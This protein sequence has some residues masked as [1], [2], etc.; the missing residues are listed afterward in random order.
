MTADWQ[1]TPP[2]VKGDDDD[3]NDDSGFDSDE[4][5]ALLEMENQL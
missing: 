5:E 4:M 2:D 1:D 3:D